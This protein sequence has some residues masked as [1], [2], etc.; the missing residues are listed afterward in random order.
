MKRLTDP[1]IVEP[2]DIIVKV[3]L[4]CICGSDLHVFYEHEKGLDQRYGNGA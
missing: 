4:S 2:T 3:S 1:I